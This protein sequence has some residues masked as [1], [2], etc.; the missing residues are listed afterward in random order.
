[1]ETPGPQDQLVRVKL[2]RLFVGRQPNWVAHAGAHGRKV[3]FPHRF[4][5]RRAATGDLNLEPRV[6]VFSLRDALRSLLGSRLSYR[7]I[8]VAAAGRRRW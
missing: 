8:A 2:G 7:S 6:V 3:G 4:P 1:M 5:R